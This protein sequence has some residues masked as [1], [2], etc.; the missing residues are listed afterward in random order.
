MGIIPDAALIDVAAS[1]AA[2]VLTAPMPV[3]IATVLAVLTVIG[4]RLL[5]DGRGWRA[6][7]NAPAWLRARLLERSPRAAVAVALVPCLARR[8]PQ[9]R[10]PRPALPDVAASR[11][12]RGPPGSALPSR[13]SDTGDGNSPR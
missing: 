10:T 8:V 6:K 9:T 1:Y 7:T 3:A 11:L 4:L 5:G 13:R 2:D 12:L